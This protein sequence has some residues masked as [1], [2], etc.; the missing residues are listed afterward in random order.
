MVFSTA[1]K[2]ERIAPTCLLTSPIIMRQRPRRPV[3]YE[4]ALQPTR[5]IVACVINHHHL[6]LIVGRRR[7][8]HSFLTRTRVPRSFD[9][10]VDVLSGRRR[11]LVAKCVYLKRKNLNSAGFQ[12]EPGTEPVAALSPSR[13]DLD[14]EKEKLGQ[15][16]RDLQEQLQKKHEQFTMLKQVL[17]IQ[18]TQAAAPKP[19]VS[20]P[21]TIPS[22]EQEAKSESVSVLN[23]PKMVS[24]PAPA[25]RSYLMQGTSARPPSR[26]MMPFRG[27]GGRW[28]LAF[29]E[30]F[31][32]YDHRTRF[33]DGPK[34][35]R[36]RPPP[37]WRGSPGC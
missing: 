33:K 11:R 15:M 2:P 25:P 16:E 23:E 14:S 37:H 1:K 28:R 13:F 24:S 4:A 26:S 7:P 32:P 29:R 17:Q 5:S 34:G 18:K 30:Q 8:M 36:K 10:T 3:I 9:M 21:A 19:S 20:A 27:G 6:N 31:R 22:D 12:Q 35:S